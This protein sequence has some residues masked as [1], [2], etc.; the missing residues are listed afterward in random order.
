MPKLKQLDVQGFKSF[1]DS[2]KFLYPT[3]I[4]AIVGP[5][6]SGK[7]NVAD[8]IRWVLGEQRMTAIRGHTGEDMIFAGSKKRARAGMARAAITFDN[9]DGWLQVD[10]AEV[11]IE[12]RTY[13]DGKT[14]YMLNGNKVRLMDLRDLLDRAGLGRD[15]YLI[16]GQG[17]VDHVLSL[18]PKERL[19]LFEQAAG[20]APYRTRRE[21]AAKRMEQ[22]HHNLERV[23]DIVGELEP[24]LRRLKRQATRAEQHAELTQELNVTLRTWYG[25]TWGRAVADLEQARQRVAYR[26]ERALQR[27][28]A[29]EAITE[30]IVD[31]RHQIAEVRTR[32]ADLHRESGAQHTEAERQQRELAVARERRRQLLERQEESQANLEPLRS[33]LEAETQEVSALHADLDTS[34]AQLRET[35]VRLAEAE[36]AQRDVEKRREAVLHHQG[37]AQAR[38]LESRHRLADRQSRLEQI[39]ERLEQLSQRVAELETALA[40]ATRRRRAQQTTVEQARRALEQAEVEAHLVR[41]EVENLETSLSDARATSERLRRER[42]LQ[43][44]ELQ[45]ITARLEA[46][47]RLHTEGAGLYAGVRA[48]LQAT[49]EGKLHGLPGTVAS[50]V[51]VPP[52]LDRAIETALGTQVQNVIADR[53][54]DAQAAIEWLK[55]QRAGRA[56]FLPLNTLRPPAILEIPKNANGGIVGVASSLVDYDARYHPA[57]VLLLGRTAIAESLDA[58]RNLYRQ[59]QGSFRIVTLDGEIVRSGGAVT[60]GEETRSRGGLLARERERRELPEQAAALE[61]EARDLDAA[62]RAKDA[63]VQTLT[64][65]AKDAAD[66]RRE[67]DQRRQQANHA[68]ENEVRTLDK[69]IQGTEWQRNLRDEVEQ[70]QERLA[71]SQQRLEQER[72]EAETA[73]VEAEA[74]LAD[75]ARELEAL[76]DDETARITAELRTQAALAEQ[77]H[78]NHCVLAETQQREAHRLETQIIAQEHRIR[79][80]GGELT[81]LE[82]QLSTLQSRYDEVRTAAETLSTQIPPLEKQLAEMERA[83]EQH[84]VR[85]RES[86]RLLREVEQRLSQAEVEAN[87][88]EDH[89]QALHREIEETLGIV[90]GDLPETLSAQQPLPLDAIVAPLPV[91]KELPEGLERQIRD[92]RTQI[93]RLEPVNLAAKEEYDEV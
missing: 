65:A 56:T 55:Q 90:V 8:A 37:Q 46:L 23:Y 16:I 14:D 1:A 93:R 78:H 35:Q 43:Q 54:D 21:E 4:T 69:L 79:S 63:E 86:R 68:L 29:T 26:E 31:L 53:W 42:G 25:Y 22:T 57:I 18:R 51:R 62:L 91:V 34:A 20:I 24:R 32:L 81:A 64:Q 7:S 9:S 92:L 71:T 15:A 49:G 74:Q 11:T 19:T 77:V 33:A 12:R 70:E 28:Q 80:L 66:Q 50:L 60:G 75:A 88:R 36:A 58:A 30:S 83:V 6:G 17:L 10:F 2:L 72:T 52:H 67:A 38:A 84:E 13:R 44:A 41:T 39:T 47:E 82:S 85:E 3:G 40:D 48:V 61:N 45:R 59:L 89:V 27:L 76:S 73:L 87:R 5:N